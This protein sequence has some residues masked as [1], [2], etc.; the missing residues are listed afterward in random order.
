M[1]VATH[2]FRIWQRFSSELMVLGFI[3]FLSWCLEQAEVFKEISSDLSDDYS[4]F[5]DALSLV[6]TIHAVHQWI[7]I[8]FMIHF[9]TSTFVVYYI[10]TT[11]QRKIAK[12]ERWVHTVHRHD[13][14]PDAECEELKDI[15]VIYGN[16]YANIR[17]RFVDYCKVNGKQYLVG[18]TL[19]DEAVQQMDKEDY[20]EEHHKQYHVTDDYVFSLYTTLNQ[21]RVL[22]DFYHFHP[23]SWG[24]LLILKVIESLILYG[25]LDT[26]NY[27]WGY[28]FG[29][30]LFLAT[31]GIIVGLIM[32]VLFWKLSERNM[33]G[34]KFSKDRMCLCLFQSCCKFENDQSTELWLGR[35]FQAFSFTLAYE[36]AS[37]VGDKNFWDAVDI[38]QYPMS[39]SEYHA[40]YMCILLVCWPVFGFI[41]TKVLI[42]I[43]LDFSMPPYMDKDHWHLVKTS[44]KAGALV[45]KHWKTE[46]DVFRAS[47]NS[48]QL[49]QIQVAVTENKTDHDEL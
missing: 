45:H 21:D 17:Q 14:H 16:K 4:Q 6:H 40:L 41:L 13:K 20:N 19:D 7:F 12:Y 47:L 43:C 29:C 26:H 25:T 3:S 48:E 46:F 8:A 34:G 1:G 22:T 15:D 28:E 33:E 42:T 32:I 23:A 37:S 35:M 36:L 49:Q 24:F 27:Q 10:V 11:V 2:M 5:P 18:K 44:I 9:M 39:A 30:D 38:A 31:V